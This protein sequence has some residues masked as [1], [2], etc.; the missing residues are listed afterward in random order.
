MGLLGGIGDAIGGALDSAADAVGIPEGVQDAV[1]VVGNVATG[2][3]VDAAQ[4]GGDLA[5]NLLG[6]GS[7]NGKSGPPAVTGTGSTEVGSGGQFFGQ[8]VPTPPGGGMGMNLGPPSDDVPQEGG[9]QAGTGMGFGQAMMQEL[10][11]EAVES[12]DAE[13]IFEAMA[14][15]ALQKL[16]PIGKPTKVQTPRGT[17]N[18]SPPGYRTVYLNDEPFAVLKP[19]ATS[20]GMID[21]GGARTM[22]EKMDDAVR[23]F[24]KYRRYIE[25][26]APK[27]GLKTSNRKSGPTR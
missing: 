3:F 19:L 11:S 21:D 12:T 17:R 4:Q 6:S 1:G 9:Q 24:N 18:V 2:D 10:V 25:D 15:G 23:E 20:L 22:R 16:G 26:I 13:A 14:S 27:A 8:N 5:G 7:G